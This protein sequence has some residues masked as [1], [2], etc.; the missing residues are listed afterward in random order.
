MT[1]SNLA[2]RRRKLLLGLLAAAQLLF[3]GGYALTHYAV[4]WY[5]KEIVLDTVP[6]DPRDLLYGDY[7]IL[8]YEINTLDHSL[9]DSKGD[10]PERGD[11]IYVTIRKDA[12][13]VYKASAASGHYPKQ[14]DSHASVLKGRVEYSDDDSLHIRYGLEKYYVP[15]YTGKILEQEAG[16]LRVKAKVGYRGTAVIEELAAKPS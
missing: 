8:S 13:G 3:L 2:N 4:H 10:L 9:W 6:V 11:I 16:N 12:A 14:S 1:Q 5:G 15:E 7:V